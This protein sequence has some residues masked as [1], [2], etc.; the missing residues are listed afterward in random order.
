MVIDER[1][2]AFGGMKF[3]GEIEVLGGNLPRCHFSDHKSHV[4]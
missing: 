2:R 3:A 4:N 1:N